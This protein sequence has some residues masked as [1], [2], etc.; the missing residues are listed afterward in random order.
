LEKFDKN[1][2]GLTQINS[3]I[4][5]PKSFYLNA[6]LEKSFADQ[7]ISLKNYLPKEKK[8]WIVK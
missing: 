4:F 2:K 6:K 8:I 1:K 7:I 3:K 5:Y